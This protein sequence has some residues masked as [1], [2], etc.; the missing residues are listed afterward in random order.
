LGTW[1]TAGRSDKRALTIQ[2]PGGIT[3]TAAQIAA[4][5]ASHLVPRPRSRQSA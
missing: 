2:A 5:R 4:V 3:A 1:F